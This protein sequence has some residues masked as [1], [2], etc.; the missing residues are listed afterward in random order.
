MKIVM[1]SGHGKY[2]RG[3]SG[4]IDEVDEARKVVETTAKVLHELGV[5]IVTYH[6]DVS[7]LQNENLNRI[8]DFH[9]SQGA[10]DLDISVHFNAY[11]TTSKAMGTECLYV[12]Q[13]ELAVKVAQAIANAGKFINRGSKHRG[14]LFFLNQTAEPSILIEVC[15][16][17]SKAD[18]DLYH[19]NYSRICQAIAE[20]VSGKKLEATRHRLRP[21]FKS[22]RRRPSAWCILTISPRQYLVV[23]PTTK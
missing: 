16:V 4:Y 5:G 15:F 23:R 2:V 10:H 8:V 7:K 14:D 11:E 18:V 3:A 12:T 21:R 19:A 13:N 20:A 9:N 1:S 22:L 6:D 17:D